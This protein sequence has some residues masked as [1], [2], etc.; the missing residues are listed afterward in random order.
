VLGRHGIAPRTLCEVEC[1]A[2]ETLRELSGL[3]DPGTRFVGYE[4]SPAAFAVCSQKANDRLMFRLGNL[5]ETNEH[6]DI[7]MAIDVIGRVE[8]YFGLLRALRPKAH[9]KIFHIPL[10]LS[11]QQVMRAGPLIEARRSAGHLHHFSKATALATLEDCGY[12]VIDHFYTSGRTAS[13]A[14]GWKARLLDWPRQALFRLSPDTAVRM[15]G[16]HSLVVLAR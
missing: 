11:A 6:Y 16:G 15:L 4:S 12:R 1:G 13:G 14:P 2:G 10:E 9:Y 8:D 3:L 7:V 5:L